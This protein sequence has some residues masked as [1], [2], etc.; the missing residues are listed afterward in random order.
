MPVAVS[1]DGGWSYANAQNL[2]NK[3]QIY[4]ADRPH[5]YYFAIMDC[6][7]N[8]RQQFAQNLNSMPRVLIEWHLQNQGGDEFSYE[9]QGSFRL[10]CLLLVIQFLFGSTVIASYIKSYRQTERYLS[11]HPIMLG[12]LLAQILSCLLSTLHLWL[13]SYDGEGQ[14]VLDILSKVAQAFSE[15]TM[16]ILLVSLASGWTVT[17]QDVDLDD[18]IEIYVPV[19]ALVVMVH[20][21]VSSLTFID[22]ES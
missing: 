11:P 10:T 20:V 4:S 18:K 5:I 15:M 22:D 9:D 12:S 17:Y 19:T 3:T 2:A 8:F 16:T 7:G 1:L 14:L 21:L 6:N 13:Y